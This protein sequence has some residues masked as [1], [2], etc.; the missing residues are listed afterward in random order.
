MKRLPLSKFLLVALFAIVQFSFV[1]W[2]QLAMAQSQAGSAAQS[3]AG[4]ESQSSAGTES[5][6]SAATQS[7]TQAGTN[8]Q[9]QATT[10]N[11][12][13]AGTTA[14]SPSTPTSA[15]SGTDAP[16]SGT[17][18]STTPAPTAA[19]TGADIA[20]ASGTKMN[21]VEAAE[22][23]GNKN[24]MELVEAFVMGW[25]PW[26]ATLIIDLI[27]LYKVLPTWW[28]RIATA[29][30]SIVLSYPSIWGAFTS[31]LGGTGSTTAWEFCIALL[32]VTIGSIKVISYWV[33]N[34]K[35]PDKKVVGL[36]YLSALAAVGAALAMMAFVYK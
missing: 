27:I 36:F 26:T 33:V 22:Q 24:A 8:A 13:Q 9:T 14:G 21:G 1:M 35:F 11:Q 4:T 7:Q 25:E 29:V 31:F 6:S 16:T 12:T 20:P 2:C 28:K 32:M 18:S 19:T 3:S 15:P 30:L 5:Q 10:D 17:T 23:S 34:E